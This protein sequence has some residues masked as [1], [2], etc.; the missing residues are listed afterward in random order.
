MNDNLLNQ[1]QL[2][3]ADELVQTRESFIEDLK[4]TSNPVTSQLAEM[5]QQTSPSDW[6]DSIDEKICP[7]QFP[8]YM[9]LVQIEAAMCQIDIGQFGFCCD[10][11]KEIEVELLNQDPTTQRCKYCQ[12]K[13]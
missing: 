10:C 9:R 12:S 7:S 3:L 6:I 1:Y 4:T 2:K 11:E 13:S 8:N 5:L